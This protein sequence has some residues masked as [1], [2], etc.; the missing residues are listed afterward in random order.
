MKHKLSSNQKYPSSHRGLSEHEIPNVKIR[1]SHQA[2]T[3]R[4]IRH[5]S[6][7][8]AKARIQCKHM[9][10]HTRHMCFHISKTSQKLR[11]L[12]KRQLIAYIILACKRSTIVEVR[13]CWIASAYNPVYHIVCTYNFVTVLQ[14]PV[15]I[16][17]F[18]WPDY[19]QL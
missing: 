2:Q 9:M 10:K 8:T 17:Q 19:K 15:S 13:L 14:A 3:T 6:K 12:P 5:M 7:I 4:G 11:H 16:L 18:L 1:N